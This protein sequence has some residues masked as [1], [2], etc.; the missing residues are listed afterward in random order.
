MKILKYFLNVLIITAF[1]F[2]VDIVVD[3]IIDLIAKETITI[4]WGG[5]LFIAVIIGIVL[6]FIKFKKPHTKL[7]K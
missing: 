5:S 4:D 3:M 1:A 2:T 7:K 6:P